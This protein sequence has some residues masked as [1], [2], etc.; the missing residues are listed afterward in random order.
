MN[1]DNKYINTLLSILIMTA[2]F[3]ILVTD[4]I[5]EFMFQIF[6]PS[7]GSVLFMLFLLEF[8]QK[9]FSKY[10]TKTITV[11]A[12]F[13][14]PLI[15]LSVSRMSFVSIQMEAVITVYYLFIAILLRMLCWRFSAG[16]SALLVVLFEM[17]VF[18]CLYFNNYDLWSVRYLVVFLTTVLFVVNLK[19]GDNR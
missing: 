13:T 11:S 17:M 1:K 7:F 8:D 14:V 6:Y 19:M 9:S 15:I 12:I 18:I 2:L 4:S 16:I 5:F 3:R 10:L